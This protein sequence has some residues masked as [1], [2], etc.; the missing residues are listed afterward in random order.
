MMM[1]TADEIVKVSE[2]GPVFV[3][4]LSKEEQV[5]DMEFYCKTWRFWV[6]FRMLQPIQL[7]RVEKQF[8]VLYMVME[9]LF[10]SRK[11][12]GTSRT[13]AKPESWNRNNHNAS[14]L[15]MVTHDYA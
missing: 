10:S 13:Y 15:P 2:K 14:P 12:F 4:D 7:F 5:A 1:G 6:C 9:K 11:D 3:E 8:I